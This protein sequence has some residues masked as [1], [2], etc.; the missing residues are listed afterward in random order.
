MDWSDAQVAL[1]PGW[2]CGLEAPIG[3]KG[4]RQG[5]SRQRE[6][7]DELPMVQP[8]MFLQQGDVLDDRKRP[9]RPLDNTGWVGGVRLQCREPLLV[10]R[11]KK[12]TQL[13]MPAVGVVGGQ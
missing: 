13:C 4:H 7:G 3:P 9:G 5:D 11:L 6:I 12:A 2:P 8:L 10:L 1:S